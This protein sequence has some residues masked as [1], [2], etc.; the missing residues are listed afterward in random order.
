MPEPEYLVPRESSPTVFLSEHDEAWARQY[1]VEESLIRDALGETSRTIDHA[2]STSV[3]GLVAKPI[4][5]ILLTVVDPADESTYVQPLESVGY[6]F[7]LREPD[8]HEHRL[9]K[10]GTPHFSPDRPSDQPRV[11]LHVFPHGCDE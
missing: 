3:P 6:T 5:D 10:K 8:W 1:A 11:N 4:V 9:F 7:H 2:G